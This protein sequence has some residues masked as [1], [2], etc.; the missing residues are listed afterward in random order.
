MK[1]H[2]LQKL[3]DSIEK[4]QEQLLL[5]NEKSLTAKERNAVQ[6]AKTGIEDAVN[7][8]QTAIL[9]AKKNEPAKAPVNLKSLGI[10]LRGENDKFVST[11]L[12]GYI[13]VPYD[14]IVDLLGE[15]NSQGDDYKTD[16]EWEI[17][18]N[19]K[20]MT[21]YNYKSG[22]NYCGSEGLETEDITEWHIG[23]ADDVTAEIQTLAKALGGKPQ[24]H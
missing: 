10:K 8:I 20:V 11:S 19:G 5:V 7:A 4:A 13:E 2:P 18:M 23:A 21:I 1:R 9:N 14:N 24:I 16:A 17:E 3:S 12:A 6:F 22:K 15:P